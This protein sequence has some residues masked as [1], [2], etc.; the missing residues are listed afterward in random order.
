MCNCFNFAKSTS[1]NRIQVPSGSRPSS[2]DSESESDCIGSS[3][4]KK[5]SLVE[6]KK[7]KKADEAEADAAMEDGE[8]E[9]SDPECSIVNIKIE[10][11][12]FQLECGMFCISFPSEASSKF[13][14]TDH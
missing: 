13:G 7:K 6:Y 11:L 8:I 3:R 10:S 14:L 4:K 1:Q 5:I 2:S 12:Y 9:D